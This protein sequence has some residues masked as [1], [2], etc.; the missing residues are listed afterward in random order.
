MHIGTLKVDAQ[1]G[2][3]F[4]ESSRIISN[5]NGLFTNIFQDLNDKSYRTNLSIGAR[6]EDFG[7]S[8][9]VFVI[10]ENRYT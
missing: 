7:A 2:R 9:F 3:L 4:L 10:K 6:D 5:V 1:R 8:A